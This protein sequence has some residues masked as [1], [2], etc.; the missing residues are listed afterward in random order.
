[1]TTPTAL[2]RGGILDATGLA[3]KPDQGDREV[4]GEEG[5]R[6]PAVVRLV[7][8]AVAA[9]VVGEVVDRLWW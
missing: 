9:G 3:R 8:V 6:G 4:N 5:G 1:M 7:M 2:E